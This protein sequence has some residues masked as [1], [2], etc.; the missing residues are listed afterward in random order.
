[1]L[2]ASITVAVLSLPVN[3]VLL[4]WLGAP[5]AAFGFLALNGFASG[6]WT[7]LVFRKYRRVHH[8]EA[9]EYAAP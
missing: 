5:G 1:L 9:Y 2:A 6:V 8:A 4:R 7:Y 3:Y